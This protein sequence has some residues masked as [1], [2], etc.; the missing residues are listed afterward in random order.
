MFISLTKKKKK[1]NYDNYGNFVAETVV[2]KV[3]YYIP[4]LGLR[5]W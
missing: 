5:R 4:Y 1:I 2:L 3:L